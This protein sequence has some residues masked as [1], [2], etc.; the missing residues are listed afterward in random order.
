[1]LFYRSKKKY[2]H[3]GVRLF[4]PDI[5][6][7]II[8]SRSFRF[9]NII[10]RICVDQLVSLLFSE[11]L[12]YL[13]SLAMNSGHCYFKIFYDFSLNSKSYYSKDEKEMEWNNTT[14]SA[15]KYK[16]K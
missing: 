4:F 3:Y 1:M 11:L 6:G 10:I 15:T 2:I 9:V 5:I 8:I 12:S 16:Y 7:M 13:G 14:F